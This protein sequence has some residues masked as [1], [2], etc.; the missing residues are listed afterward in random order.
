[1][2]AELNLGQAENPLVRLERD[3]VIAGHREF[4]SAAQ[5]ETVDYGHGGT[6]QGLELV[7]RERRV[8]PF[9]VTG[10][11]GQRD[12]GGDGD[13]DADADTDADTDAGAGAG[14]VKL[15]SHA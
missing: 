15:H 5:R 7:Q 14:A 8:S 6:G 12:S 13:T 10:R 11:L 4:E 3:P 2:N 1:M 9:L